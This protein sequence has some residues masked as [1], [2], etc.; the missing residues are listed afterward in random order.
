[1]A[2]CWLSG[3]PLLSSLALKFGNRRGRDRSF[4]DMVESRRSFE[5]T[6]AKDSPDIDEMLG[7]KDAYEFWLQE[8][9]I[10][11]GPLNHVSPNEIL[12]VVQNAFGKEW[13]D[14][15]IKEREKGTTLNSSRHPLAGM[16]LVPGETQI[17]A[18]FELGIYLKELALV[19]CLNDVMRQ[20]K[21]KDD[22][23]NTL[24]Q[25]AYGFRF[26]KIGATDLA[27]EPD[28]DD[29]RK[30]D[31]LFKFDGQQ[32]LAECF[33]PDGSGDWYTELGENS[34]KRIFEHVQHV[35]KKVFFLATIRNDPPFNIDVSNPFYREHQM[36]LWALITVLFFV[37]GKTF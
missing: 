36:A 6:V 26:S 29:G 24:I 37:E 30:A 31:I 32:Y 16:F 21:N 4:A 19:P 18:M 12:A 14:E 11:A 22:F 9:A 34:Q 25:L 33:R 13:L 7:R 27:F 23:E 10:H 5:E 15:K 8:A 35:D 3:T 17:R 20:L 2:E 1:L 28:V